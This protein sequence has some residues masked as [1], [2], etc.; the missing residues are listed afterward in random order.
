MKTFPE[1]FIT[2]TNLIQSHLCSEIFLIS[3]HKNTEK[4]FPPS[5]FLVCFYK[6][7]EQRDKQFPAAIFSKFLFWRTKLQKNEFW[8]SVKRNLPSRFED[9]FFVFIRIYS[10][11]FRIWFL[12]VNTNNF[13]R[14]LINFNSDAPIKKYCIS[15]KFRKFLFVLF[16]AILSIAANFRETGA[17]ELLTCCSRESRLI[18]IFEQKRTR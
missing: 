1:H 8:G 18:L 11:Y 9:K 16:F 13:Q 5:I 12:S 17:K 10:D 7:P 6:T 3:L 15:A 4:L 14:F 2:Y